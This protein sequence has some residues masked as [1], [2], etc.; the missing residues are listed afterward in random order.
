MGEHPN[1]SPNGRSTLSQQEAITIVSAS[2]CTQAKNPAEN[3][4]FSHW[5]NSIPSSSILISR[6]QS[7]VSSSTGSIVWTHHW[8]STSWPFRE[9][10]GK[11]SDP[12]QQSAKNNAGG[13]NSWRYSGL[14][15][16]EPN[17]SFTEPGEPKTEPTCAHASN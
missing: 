9:Y 6:Q 17:E 13:R 10:A 7:P 8:I 4:L 14:T 5:S 2:H 15:S 3:P 16:G 12:R 1:A 11:A